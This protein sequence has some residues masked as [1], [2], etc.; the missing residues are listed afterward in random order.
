MRNHRREGVAGGLLD[1]EGMSMRVLPRRVEE[2][3]SKRWDDED[4]MA[5]KGE[6]AVVW[7]RG[8]EARQVARKGR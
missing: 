3:E 6:E 5:I 4:A 8:K 2:F 7:R 1:G